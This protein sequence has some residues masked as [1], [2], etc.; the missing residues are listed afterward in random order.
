[1][2]TIVVNLNDME[3]VREYD[4]PPEKAVINAYAQFRGDYNTW[5]YGKYEKF[6]KE[7]QFCWFCG[8]R[9]NVFSALKST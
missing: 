1:M 2:K 9:P 8:V 6:L 7:G 5:D 4:L 3:N